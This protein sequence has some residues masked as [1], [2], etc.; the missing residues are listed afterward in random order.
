MWRRVTLLAAMMAGVLVSS[1]SPTEAFLQ[2]ATTPPGCGEGHQRRG[3]SL[4][5]TREPRRAREPRWAG[6]GSS[7]GLAARRSVVVSMVKLRRAT[8]EDVPGIVALAGTRFC[9]PVR[10][11]SIVRCSGNAAITCHHS[12]PRVCCTNNRGRTA[13]TFTWTFTRHVHSE[14]VW[15]GRPGE[16]RRQAVQ[17]TATLKHPAIHC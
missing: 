7:Y 1:P 9:S 6:R 17:V 2:Q 10:S 4:I 11:S 12:P 13:T 8:A 3:P 16:H 14:Y 5:R 15:G